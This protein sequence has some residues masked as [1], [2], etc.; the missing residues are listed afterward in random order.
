LTLARF[1]RG[2]NLP[3]DNDLMPAPEPLLPLE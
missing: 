3:E 1:L 2:D